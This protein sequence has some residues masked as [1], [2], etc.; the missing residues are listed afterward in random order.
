METECTS[1]WISPPASSWSAI[2]RCT[3]PR[4]PARPGRI[5]AAARQTPAVDVGLAVPATLITAAWQA[6]GAIHVGAQDI[7]AADKGAHTGCLSAPM[8]KDAGAAFTIV[9]H[10]ECRAGRQESDA[11]V[12]GKARRR[13]GT[14]CR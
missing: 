1:L 13:G 4:R 6:A 3:A 2:G 10:S 7:H 14:A 5:D 8:V 9:G 12:R 11:E